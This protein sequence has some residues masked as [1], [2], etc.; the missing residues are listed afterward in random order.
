[1]TET[2]TPTDVADL[3]GRWTT[4]RLKLEA[5]ADVLARQ[6][7]LVAKDAR[8]RRVWVVRYVVQEGGRRAHKA[9][10]IGGDDVPELIERTRSLLEECRRIGRWA[11]EVERYARMAARAGGIARHMATGRGRLG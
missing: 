3:E 4:L 11:D 1:M 9:I 2:R 5:N 10:Y 6:G 7:T 8:G